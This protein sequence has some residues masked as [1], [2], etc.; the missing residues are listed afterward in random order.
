M[1]AA[2]LLANGRVCDAAP[3]VSAAQELAE[4]VEDRFANDIRSEIPDFSF[5]A[6]LALQL[7]LA[8]GGSERVS[9]CLD[10]AAVWARNRTALAVFAWTGSYGGRVDFLAGRW[11]SARARLVEAAQFGN[12]TRNLWQ[13]WSASVKLAEIAAAR[14]AVDECREHEADAAEAAAGWG[15]MTFVCDLGRGASA[16]LALG[17][18]Q[19][20]AAAKAYDRDVLPAAGPLKLYPQVAD[21]I[22]ALVRAGRTAD[23]APVAAV[24]AEQAA[25]AGWAWA[26]ARGAHLRALLAPGADV[27]DE[28]LHW[29]EEASQ[30]FPRAR[31]QLAYGEWLR[32]ANRRIDARVQLH[33][34]LETFEQLGAEPWAEQARAELRAT[35][36]RV[37]ARA[38]LRTTVLTAQE[39]TIAL[40]VARG[41]TNKEA[42]A[43]LFLSPKT[44]EKRLGSV[45]T[46]LGLRSRTEL[47]A[48]LASPPI[49]SAAP[50]TA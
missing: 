23:A 50:P 13:I 7:L 16:L 22:E 26:L 32:R 29:H 40:T 43:Q 44:I 31:T 28:A 6:M 3:L 5:R 4:Q 10:A 25:D 21:A 38:G 20:E 30:P 17:Q 14:G 41:A 48:A 15:A 27:F 35:G 1:V 11:T 8:T 36:E 39:L 18:K 42:A 34:A 2:A 46:K 49:A 45:Y 37:R 24:F 9:R 47:A 12:E 33:A 19:Y